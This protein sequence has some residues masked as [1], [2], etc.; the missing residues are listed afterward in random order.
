MANQCVAVHERIGTWARHLRA[1]LAG[2]PVRLVETRSADDLRAA[3][4]GVPCPILLVDVGQRPR[5]ALEELGTALAVAPDA[6]ALVLNPLAHDGVGL[7]ARELGATHVVDGPCPPPGVAAL[8]TRWLPL[9][10][11]RA[12]QSGRVGSGPPCPEPEPEPWGPPPDPP[13]ARTDPPGPPRH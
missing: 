6:L 5:A 9:A 8:L 12:E 2:H 11:R 4:D 7:L 1:R 10:H 3:L 13:H